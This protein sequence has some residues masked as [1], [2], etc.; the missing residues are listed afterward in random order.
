MKTQNRMKIITIIIIIIAI[1]LV[2]IGL[3]G[4]KESKINQDKDII[5][6]KTPIEMCYYRR[7]PTDSGFSDVAWIKLNILDEKI[8]GEFQHLPAESDS[9]VGTFEGTVGPL[10]QS[11]MGRR[12]LVWWDSLAEGMNVKE[13]LVIEFGD[14]SAT[15][16]FGEMID[17]GD[18]VYIYK[19]KAN[20]YYIDQMSQMD[21][22]SLDEKLFVEKYI[23]DNIATIATDKAVLGGTWYVTI[24]N[25]IPA[26]DTGEVTYEDG[27]IQS[28]ANFVYTYQKSPQNITITKFEVKK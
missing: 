21:C 9:K 18:G 10:D 15:V 16:G 25:V 24:V 26:T 2:I 8:T 22:E 28:K 11:I 6:G 13:E 4:N 27:H 1:V 20:I 3:G 17:R 14:G 12:A 5:G 7:T 19:D 23:R